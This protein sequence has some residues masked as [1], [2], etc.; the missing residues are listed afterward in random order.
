[1]K[2]LITLGL[3]SLSTFAI[4]YPTT[5][6]QV[7]NTGY[8]RDSYGNT[9]TYNQVGNTTYAR[10]SSGSTTTYNQVGVVYQKVC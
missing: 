2:L 6:N 5:Y 10:D 8:Q 7:G 1:M 4:A 9:T 3:I